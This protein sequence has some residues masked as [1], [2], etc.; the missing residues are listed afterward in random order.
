MAGAYGTLHLVERARRQ[1]RFLKK[2]LE[3][4]LNVN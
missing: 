4:I 3:F 1:R 2:V